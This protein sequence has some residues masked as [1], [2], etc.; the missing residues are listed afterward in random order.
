MNTEGRK[1]YVGNLADGATKEDVETFFSKFGEIEAVWIAR[2][3]AGFAFVT[4]VQIE[5]ANAA[6]DA[7]TAEGA[8][9]LQGRTLRIELAKSNGHKRDRMDRGRDNGDRRMDRRGDDRRGDDRIRRDYDRRDY[10]RRD[11]DRKD[12]RRD[13]D[14]KDDR[15]DY[16]RRVERR[17]DRRDAP[18]RD[19]RRIVDSP[20]RDAPRD[21]RTDAPRDSPRWD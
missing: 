1:L 18:R 14:R 19:E 8:E 20:P 15:R 5:H 13:Y 11:Y 10:D 3:P 7:I 4:F 6:M 12:D 2:N 16:D 17:D 21:S 9:Q